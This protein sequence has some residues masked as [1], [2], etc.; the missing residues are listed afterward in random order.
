MP[1]TSSIFFTL[2]VILPA[3]SV[4]KYRLVTNLDIVVWK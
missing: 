4:G 3:I 2:C 1:I